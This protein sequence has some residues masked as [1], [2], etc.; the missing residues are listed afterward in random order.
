[1]IHMEKNHRLACVVIIKSLLHVIVDRWDFISMAI[2]IA[3]I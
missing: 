2:V 3:P 1:V